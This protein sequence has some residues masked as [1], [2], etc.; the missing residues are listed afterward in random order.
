MKNAATS[1]ALASERTRKTTVSVS[2]EIEIVD[3]SIS[4]AVMIAKMM[5]IYT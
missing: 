5:K 3:K 2:R 1:E 4:T